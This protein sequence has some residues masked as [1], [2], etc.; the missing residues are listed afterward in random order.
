MKFS[1]DE[2]TLIRMLENCGGSY[3]GDADSKLTRD[4]MRIANRLERKGVLIIEA[5]DDGPRFTLR[6]AVHG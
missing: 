6:E 5:T 1:Q 3:C 4:A 2:L